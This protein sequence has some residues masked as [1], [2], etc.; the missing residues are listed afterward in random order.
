MSQHSGGLVLSW[1]SYEAGR[2]TEHVLWCDGRVREVG[3]PSI[4]V[5]DSDYLDLEWL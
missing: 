4:R 3:D 2:F 1:H 5:L